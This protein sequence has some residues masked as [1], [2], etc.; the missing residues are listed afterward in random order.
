MGKETLRCEYVKCGKCKGNCAHGPYWYAYWREDGR[1]RKRYVGKG[2]PRERGDG[3]RGA[4]DAPK[5][6]PERPHAHDAIFNDR[7]APH[8]LAR[9]ILG[10]SAWATWADIQ[11]RYR[12][13]CKIMHPDKNPGVDDKPFRRIQAAF[14]YL[15]R[16][17]S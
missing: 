12:T 13:L 6:E 7:T 5:P 4:E 10:V 3:T 14:A 2:D 8:G 1:L 17:L 15:R 9:Q 16:M 11:T